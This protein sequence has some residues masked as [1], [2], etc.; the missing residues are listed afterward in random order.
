M[1]TCARCGVALTP[2]HGGPPRRLA[3]IAD[4]GHMTSADLCDPHY[5]EATRAALE[6]LLGQSKTLSEPSYAL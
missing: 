2:A 3:L 1:K 5:R 6:A 4:N